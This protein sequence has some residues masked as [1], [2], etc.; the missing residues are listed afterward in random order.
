MIKLVQAD[1]RRPLRPSGRHPAPASRGT[2]LCGSLVRL[3]QPSTLV[4][5]RL[6][7]CLRHVCARCLGLGCVAVLANARLVLV[8]R[9]LVSADAIGHCI[10]LKFLVSSVQTVVNRTSWGVCKCREHRLGRCWLFAD[11]LAAR[12]MPRLH[13][14]LRATDDPEAALAAALTDVAQP[15]PLVCFSSVEGLT[16]G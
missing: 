3:V 11:E 14:H 15:V 13:A 12:V 9:G 5:A 2:D 7:L 10:L 6:G 4:V 16:A 8:A 1:F